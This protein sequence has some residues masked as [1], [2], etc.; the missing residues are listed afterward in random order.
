MSTR[1]RRRYSKR[2]HASVHYP[3]GFWSRQ[4]SNSNGFVQ[5]I[6][7]P[8]AVSLRLRE[9]NAFLFKGTAV[10][11]A[12][13]T[14]YRLPVGDKVVGLTG[15]C[16]ILRCHMAAAGLLVENDHRDR[17]KGECCEVAL[18]A[19]VR[20]GYTIFYYRINPVCWIPR[21]IQCQEICILHW[22]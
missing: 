5:S 1:G 11:A 7:G 12:N 16:T 14:A 2:S 8:Y 19:T 15:T 18:I 9:P 3:Q 21:H 22:L 4:G 10:R 17:H 6:R 20:A 13:R